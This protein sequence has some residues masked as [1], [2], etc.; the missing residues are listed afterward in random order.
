MRTSIGFAAFMMQWRRE[1]ATHAQLAGVP[2]AAGGGSGSWRWPGRAEGE[3]ELGVVAG[4]GAMARWYKLHALNVPWAH[5]PAYWRL[6]SKC[7]SIGNG[8]ERAPIGGHA[9]RGG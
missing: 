6:L 7:M 1:N 8:G 2:G 5:R 9:K 3:G 4:D